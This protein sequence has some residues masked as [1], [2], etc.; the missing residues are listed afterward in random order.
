MQQPYNTTAYRYPHERLI[1]A[2]TIIL[3]LLVIALTATATLCLSAVFVVA[4]ALISYHGTRALHRSLMQRARPLSWAHT[5]ELTALAH[6]TAGKLQAGGVVFFVAGSPVLNAYTFG[7]SSP[8]VVVLHS[9]LLEVMDRA[10]L[11]FILGHE[12]GHV[13]L[14][15]TWLNTLVGGM[16]GIPSSYTSAALLAL[17]FRWWNRA[18]EYSADRAGMLACGDPTKAISALVKLAAGPLDQ[19]PGELERALARL[20]STD[21]D[22]AGNLGELLS[23]HPMAVRRIAQLRRY[24]ATAEYRRLQNLISQ[25]TPANPQSQA[26]Y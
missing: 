13:R 14:G 26:L 10:E 22:F 7:L 21:S 11:R 19:A 4:V 15:H 9:A 1:L 23:T 5:P 12:L 25:N 18:C 20:E 24:A 2:L 6:E 17:A 16:A 8:K 3:V